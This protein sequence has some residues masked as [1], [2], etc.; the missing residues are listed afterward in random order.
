M[1]GLVADSNGW[2]LGSLDGVYLW[3]SRTGAILVSES[4]AAPAGTCG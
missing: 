2:W 3:T 1:G 4:L